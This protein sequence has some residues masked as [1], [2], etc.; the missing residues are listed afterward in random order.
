ME[1]LTSKTFKMIPVLKISTLL[2]S[3]TCLVVFGSCKKEK[4]VY[5]FVITPPPPPP[6]DTLKGKEFKFEDLPWVLAGPGP[7]ADE[8][9]WIGVENR[10]DLFSRPRPVEVSIKFDTTAVWL[11]IP[12]WNSPAVPANNGFLYVMDTFYSSFYVE[13]YPL[14]FQLIGRKASVKIRFL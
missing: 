9:I 13:S 10:T 12:K 7:V 8:E 4:Y 1:S 14:S 5:S 3:M 2:L 11:T 6:V